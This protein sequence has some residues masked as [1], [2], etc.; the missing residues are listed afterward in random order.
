MCSPAYRNYLGVIHNIAFRV[1]ILCDVR[2]ECPEVLSRIQE[3]NARAF[4]EV[5]DRLHCLLKCGRG[6]EQL[7]MCHHAQKLTDAEYR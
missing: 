4:Q 3:N 2:K 5:P 6:I 1:G 7:G